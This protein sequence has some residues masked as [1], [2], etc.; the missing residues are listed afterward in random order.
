MRP[1]KGVHFLVVDLAKIKSSAS[2]LDTGLGDGRVPC[3]H[4]NNLLGDD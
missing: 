1:T 2:L 4:E 3:S